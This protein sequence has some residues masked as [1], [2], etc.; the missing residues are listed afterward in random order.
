[1][2]DRSDLLRAA[3]GSTR[4]SDRGWQGVLAAGLAVLTAAAVTAFV[5]VGDPAAADTYV[6]SV[7]RAVVVLPDGTERPARIGDRLDQGARLRT[8]QEGGARLTTAGRDVYVG[9]QSTVLVTDG[10]HETLER[11]QVMVDSRR[12]PRLAL[13]TRAGT[14]TTD[15]GALSRVEQAVVLRLG[16]FDGSATLA[17][18]GRQA[19]VAVPGLYQVTTQY[20]ALPGRP[21]ALALTNDDWEQRL[22]ADLTGADGQLVRLQA[23]LRGAEG[24]LVLRAA[25]AA[26][27]TA[28]VD[29][30]RGEQALA[31]AVAQVARAQ[32]SAQDNLATVLTSRRDGGSWGVVAAIVRASVSDVSGRL[33]QAFGTDPDNPGFVAG[34]TP[35]FPG[36]LD[37]SATSGPFGPD[38]SGGTPSPTP[39]RTRPTSPPPSSPT[40]VDQVITIVNDLLP[41]PVP[42]PSPSP[43]PKPLISIGPITIG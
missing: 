26:L 15:A 4:A 16:V 1:M 23:G 31:V 25:P 28:S 20:G 41:T 9:A 19:K 12:G 6:T 43:T 29:P 5:G 38:G 34:P 40:V 42:T 36:I 8:G 11:G 27:R 30:D 14:V 37:P 21:T 17:V 22:A 35:G 13:G 39:T 3:P 33:D 18:R 7:T 10:V 24:V 32:S 2:T